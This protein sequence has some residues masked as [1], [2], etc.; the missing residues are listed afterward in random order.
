MI[1]KAA[2]ALLLGAICMGALS[3]SAA[4]AECFRI[5]DATGY[6]NKPNLERYGIRPASVIYTPQ[7]YWPNRR[8]MERLPDRAV[9]EATVRRR[10]AVDK[11][12]PLLIIDLEHWPNVG[13]D[14]VVAETQR[15]YIALAQWTKNSAGGSAV[16]YY[17]VPPLRDYWRASKNPASSEFRA[18][19]A[20]NDRFQELAD[21][22][23]VLT[24][25]L[26][27]FYDDVDGWKRYAA[28]NIGEARRLAGGKPVYPFIWPQYHDS[29]RTLGGQQVPA[30]VWFQ[31]LQT[32]AKLADGVIIWS[33]PGWWDQSAPWWIA[34]RTFIDNAARAA[35]A[36]CH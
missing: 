19:Q 28:A 2:F 35:P 26:Y 30:S 27:T 17:G 12:P 22:V 10:V 13:S 7:H 4:A 3:E 23:D 18:W 20:E 6:K 16:G 24:P 21:V 14:A 25:S 8:H 9:V 15:K 32:L 33:P 5:F 1:L 34:T 11:S 31:Q 29:N 36:A